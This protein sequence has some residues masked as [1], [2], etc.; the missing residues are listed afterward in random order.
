MYSSQASQ[1][2]KFSSECSFAKNSLKAERL[3]SQAIVSAR[4]NRMA[5]R[6]LS[7][8][9]SRADVPLIGSW[10]K[11][12]SDSNR[13]A[14][15]SLCFL[16]S[17]AL[18]QVAAKLTFSGRDFLSPLRAPSPESPEVFIWSRLELL[19]CLERKRWSAWSWDFLDCPFAPARL[20]DDEDDF[21]VKYSS[22]CCSSNDFACS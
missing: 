18:T 9:R 5:Q 22:S 15:R 7:T 14:F 13:R 11:L 12:A 1:K 2:H 10:P 6:S 16:R 3:A 17:F 4:P 21:K 19:A 8:S 20:D